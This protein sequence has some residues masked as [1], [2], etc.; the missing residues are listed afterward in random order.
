MLLGCLCGFF[1]SVVHCF[2]IIQAPRFR[3]SFREILQCCVVHRFS[4]ASR[5][6]LHFS[7]VHRFRPALPSS[8]VHRL[9]DAS[10]PGCHLLN[11]S[12]ALNW[13]SADALV[14]VVHLVGVS[15]VVSSC[16]TVTSGLWRFPQAVQCY[17]L[18]VQCNLQFVQGCV[19][20]ALSCCPVRPHFVLCS[21]SLEHRHEEFCRLF[22]QC[23]EV[24]SSCRS[25]M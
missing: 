16:S 1:F 2:R 19:S 3:P 8:V 9:R 25:A 23:C 24:F 5:P 21:V 6:V 22:A 12:S 14:Q 20:L 17:L 4:G 13:F 10:S 18:F 11:T 15:C 7:V